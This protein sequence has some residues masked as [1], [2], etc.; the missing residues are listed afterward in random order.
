MSLCHT[1]RHI[2]YSIHQSSHILEFK[3]IEII[4]GYAY[5]RFDDLA[6]R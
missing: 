2:K 5:I 3:L 4:L 6:I 1:F